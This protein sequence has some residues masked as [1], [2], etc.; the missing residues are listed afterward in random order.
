[1]PAHKP[2][3]GR[4]DTSPEARPGARRAPVATRGRLRAELFT[5]LARLVN[6]GVVGLPATNARL[7]E[8]RLP[9][10]KGPRGAVVRLP[11]RVRARGAGPACILADARTAISTDIRRMRWTRL[12]A[13]SSS[14]GIDNPLPGQASRPVTVHA[15]VW[16]AVT[17]PAF[18]PGRFWR[19]ALTLFHD[20]LRRL[21]RV[22]A[23]ATAAASW[24]HHHPATTTHDDCDDEVDQWDDDDYSL[25]TA[26][27]IGL[28]DGDATDIPARTH[29]RR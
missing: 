26:C 13:F 6:E 17:V 16:L 27:R 25:D 23:T 1:M 19:T 28:L 29:F 14:F 18:P 22:Y 10:L 5:H 2:A 3:V 24:Q 20:D 8:L 11:V 9:P 4:T 15:D 21:R 12:D 7:A